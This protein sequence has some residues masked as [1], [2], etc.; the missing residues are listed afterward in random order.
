MRKKKKIIILSILLGVLIVGGII[1][2]QGVTMRVPS[3][4]KEYEEYI[5]CRLRRP[6]FSMA[7]P[8][9][10]PKFRVWILPEQK[11]KLF[12]DI[13]EKIR[14]LL[15]DPIENN[16]DVVT[17]YE[18][19]DDLKY[20]TIY[21]VKGMDEDR[22]LETVYYGGKRVPRRPDLKD[23]VRSVRFLIQDYRELVYGYEN[24]GKYKEVL[25]FV[26]AEE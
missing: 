8:Q 21:C 23:A 19:D 11:K 5:F 10:L 12:N 4:M 17:G 26:A 3:K 20:V 16:S 6:T 22:I 2:S 24:V 25:T 13:E 1:W 15:N 7:I 14:T 9:P 18:I